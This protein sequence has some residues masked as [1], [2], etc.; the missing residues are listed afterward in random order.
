M[1]ILLVND[2]GFDEPGLKALENALSDYD[3][4]TV[5]P[6]YHHSGAGMSLNLYSPLMVREHGRNR[7]SVQGTPV[8]CVKL[9]LGELSKHI[10][11]DLV[12]SGINPG[13]NVANNT[14]YSGTVAA[15]TE[16]AF[17]NVPAIA[18]SQEYESSP[19]FTPAASITRRLIHDGLPEMI[20]P[21]TFLNVNVPTEHKGEFRLT[22]LGSFS[23][24]IPFTREGNEMIFR[25]GPYEVQPVREKSGTDVHALQDGHVSITHLS[26]ARHSPALSQEIFSWCSRRR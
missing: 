3:T 26:A 11:P 18:V 9:A 6:F 20:A 17:W 5:A 16:A 13:A 14:W 21:G 23:R 22:S 4:L 10:L 24:E 7:F 1:R 2:D 12:I 25:Y 15:A 19:D 8:D